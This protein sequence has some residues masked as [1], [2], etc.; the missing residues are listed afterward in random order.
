MGKG[1]YRHW[2]TIKVYNQHKGKKVSYRIPTPVFEYIQAL[3]SQLKPK[4]DTIRVWEP[5]E[6]GEPRG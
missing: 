1:K 2:V 3:K 4:P 6:K 5:S